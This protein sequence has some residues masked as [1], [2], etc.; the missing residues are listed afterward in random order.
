MFLFIKLLKASNLTI[1]GC[2]KRKAFLLFLL[3]EGRDLF[4]FQQK[5]PQDVQKE[6]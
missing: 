4:V 1:N 3:H 5:G 2:V 6:S